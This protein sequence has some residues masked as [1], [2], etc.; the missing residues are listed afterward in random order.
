[1][2]LFT[3]DQYNKAIDALREAK[4]Q[5][6]DGTQHRGCSICHGDHHPDNCGMNPLFAQHLCT[7]ISEQ[8]KEMHDTLHLMTGYVTYMG[9]GVGVSRIKK[10]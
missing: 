4:Q 8:A 7:T 3:I 5:L 10:P 9:E 2:G 6:M 1:M